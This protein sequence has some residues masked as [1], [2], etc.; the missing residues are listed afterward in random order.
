MQLWRG[1]AHLNSAGTRNLSL[2]AALAV[3]KKA[4]SKAN[5]GRQARPVIERKAPGSPTL[6]SIAWADASVEQ[7]R[8]FLDAINLDEVLEALPDSWCDPLEQRV[9]GLIE[10]RCKTNKARATVHKLRRKQPPTL[11]L[12]ANP[13]AA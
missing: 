6:S 7:R 5:S 3:I 8:H 1:R 4:E 2:T 13:V 12:T 10:A 9:L 11:E